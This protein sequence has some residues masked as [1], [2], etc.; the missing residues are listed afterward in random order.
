MKGK[1]AAYAVMVIFLSSALNWGRMF[2][3]SGS[4]SSMPRSS[5]WINSGN[6]GTSSSGSHK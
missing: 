5:S 1:F 4:S 3:S 6:L 2:A